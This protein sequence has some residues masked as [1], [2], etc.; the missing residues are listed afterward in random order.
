MRATFDETV[1]YRR[2]FDVDMPEWQMFD[3]FNTY[4][5]DQRRKPS[6]TGFL[7]HL[8]KLG[9][10]VWN[11]ND[12]SENSSVNEIE[13]CGGVEYNNTCSNKCCLNDENIAENHDEI[14]VS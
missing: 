10:H 12:G 1:V 3:I 14:A 8:I 4:Y 5:Y 7:K 11:F 2:E 6:V 13:F 9:Y